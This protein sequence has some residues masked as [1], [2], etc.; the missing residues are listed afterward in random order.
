MNP[1]F[2]HYGRIQTLDSL[3]HPL[4]MEPGGLR[5][6]ARRASSMYFVAQRLPKDDGSERIVYDTRQPLKAVLQRINQH[7]LSRVQYPDYLTG[8][9][10]GKDYKSNVQIHAGAATVVKEDIANFYPSVTADVVFDVWRRFFGFA[11]EVA[12][13]LTA[14]TTRNGHLEQGAPT[15]GYLANL[16]L[17][18]VEFKLVRRLAER[19]ITAYSRHVDDMG[20]SSQRRLNGDEIAWA[21]SQLYGVLRRKGLQAKRAKHKVMHDNGPIVVLKLI[22]NEKPS[23]PAKERSRVRAIVHRFLKTAEAGTDMGRLMSELPRVRGQAYKVKRFHPTEGAQLVEQVDRAALLIQRLGATV[24]AS[25][26]V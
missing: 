22:S 5:N 14:L 11:E 9:V 25:S 23:L 16:A 12:V 7:I 24:S 6:L 13:V 19:G 4:G 18:D 8:G 21:V 20:M 3:R 26:Q 15:S 17:W 2:Y 10:P 1:P